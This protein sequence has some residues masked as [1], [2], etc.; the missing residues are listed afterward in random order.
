[1][2]T[3]AFGSLASVSIRVL[4]RVDFIIA[5]ALVIFVFLA[6]GATALVGF[7]FLNIFAGN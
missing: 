4:P 2:L 7:C 5:F 6:A 1:V 3:T